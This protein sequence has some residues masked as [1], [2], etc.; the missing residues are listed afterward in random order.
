MSLFVKVKKFLLWLYAKQYNYCNCLCTQDKVVKETTL[1][2]KPCNTDRKVLSACCN[3]TSNKR[4]NWLV[5]FRTRKPCIKLK[6]MTSLLAVSR[7]KAASGNNK[8]PREAFGNGFGNRR[9][10]IYIFYA[11][12]IIVLGPICHSTTSLLVL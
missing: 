11:E 10:F 8:G 2:I 1:Q 4:V 9:F 5:A 12:G 3:Y 6:I 7:S